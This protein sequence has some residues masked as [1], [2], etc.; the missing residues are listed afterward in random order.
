MLRA[1]LS[2]AQRNF[3]SNQKRFFTFLNKIIRSRNIFL[4][5]KTWAQKIYSTTRSR[6]TDDKVNPN[7]KTQIYINL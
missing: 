7:F 4:G 5:V 3:L 2:H 6:S 1:I